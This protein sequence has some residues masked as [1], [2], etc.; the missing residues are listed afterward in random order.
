MGYLLTVSGIY[1]SG[2]TILSGIPNRLSIMRRLV[3]DGE[4][5]LLSG[6]CASPSWSPS[7]F[8][9]ERMTSGGELLL[10]DFMVCSRSISSLDRAPSYNCTFLYLIITG[11]NEMLFIKNN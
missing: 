9:A 3:D 5:I 8:K 2:I 11:T 4:T 10:G 1:R 6:L 7:L